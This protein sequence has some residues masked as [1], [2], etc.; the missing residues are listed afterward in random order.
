MLTVDK[1][2]PPTMNPAEWGNFAIDVHNAGTV[3]AFNVTL[4]DRLPD[5]PTGGMC[6]THAANLERAR[7]RGRRRDASTG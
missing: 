3:D 4:V 2:G 1:S 5:G 6:T 7:F